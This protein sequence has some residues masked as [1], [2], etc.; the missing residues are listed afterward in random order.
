[1]DIRQLRYFVA[2]AELGSFSSAARY[3]G[4]AQPALSRHVRSLEQ[5]LGVPLLERTA[6]GVK[7]TEPGATLLQHA[8]AVIRQFDLIPDLISEAPDEVSGQVVVGLPTSANAILAQPLVSA[9]RSRL[10]GVRLHLIES[11]SGFLQTWIT[12]GRI[13]LCLLYNASLDTVLE[14]EDLLTEDLYLI[15]RAGSFSAEEAEIRFSDLSR[16]PMAMPSI[17]HALRMLLETM[18][19]SHGIPVKIA[20]EIDSLSVMMAVVANERLFTLLPRG[21]VYEQVQAGRLEARP[22][23]SPT[24]SRKVSLVKSTL[25]PQTRATIETQT[26]IIELV[27]DLIDRGVWSATMIGNER[28]AAA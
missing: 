11:L 26:L 9:V 4:V 21:T 12:S 27:E 28:S 6:R 24:I 7:T 25:R 8:N 5:K 2:I 15:G 23:V 3:L 17:T 18:A 22:I 19:L 14:V 16:Y 10:P 20:V 1:M 13:D